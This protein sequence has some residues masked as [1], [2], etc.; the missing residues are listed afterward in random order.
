[1]EQEGEMSVI[2]PKDSLKEEKRWQI[3]FYN[4]MHGKWENDL[5]YTNRKALMIRLRHYRAFDKQN[6]TKIKYRILKLTIK[7][8]V[9]G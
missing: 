5:L 7:K 2:L 3:Q 4:S 1:M 9:V 8:E 6:G